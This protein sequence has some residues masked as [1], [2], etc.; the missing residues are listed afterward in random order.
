MLTERLSNS[1]ELL[2]EQILFKSTRYLGIT[3]SMLLK[4][5]QVDSQF[6]IVFVENC[7]QIT[8]LNQYTVIFAAI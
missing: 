5:F 7:N 2:I 4:C 3:V 8:L 1:P 6:Y